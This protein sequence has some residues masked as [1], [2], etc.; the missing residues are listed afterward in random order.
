MLPDTAL[1]S[2][3]SLL[4]A[5]RDAT[6]VDTDWSADASLHFLRNYTTE[7]VDPY[8]QFH[9]VRDDIR[10]AISHGGYDTMVQELLDP[11]SDVRRDQ[12]DV[13]VMSLLVDF[14]DARCVEPEWSADDCIAKIDELVGH[15]VEKTSSLLVLNTLLP[16]VDHL[17]DGAT[18]ASL[19][20]EISRVNKR[21]LELQSR[22]SSRLIVS[23]FHELYRRSGEVDAL[24][25]RFWRA[26]QAPFRKSFLDL[27]ARDIA[28]HIRV[29]KGRSRKCL[30]LDCD[31]TLWGGVIGEEG[32][33]GI[34]LHDSDKPG[35]YFRAFQ[36]A[37]VALHDQG[38]MLAVCSKNNEDDVWEVL[39]NHPYCALKKSHLVA[40]RIN[41]EN[42][43]ANLVSLADELN[44]GLDSFVFVDDSPHERALVG[45]AL[46]DVLVLGVPDELE[47]LSNMLDSDRL[48][49]TSSGSDEDRQR[50]QM[51]R[52]ESERKREQNGYDDLT[53]YLSTL[54]TVLRIFPVDSANKARVAQL[55]Q[56]TNQFNLTT[57]RYSEADI[58]GFLENEDVA[59][60]AMSVEDR[61]GSMGITGV[62]IGR[63]DGS[64]ALIDS[65]LL[66]CRVLGRQLEFAFVDQCLRLL[67]KRW[68]KLT[69]HADFFPTRKNAQ[70]ADFWDRAGFVLE[71]DLDGS[72]HYLLPD[73]SGSA[74]YLNI[75]SVKLE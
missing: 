64:S 46:P 61:Y 3:G 14:L 16:P 31:N 36:E 39:D 71:S 72:R 42:K 70:V 15:V 2:L 22:H 27:Y 35:V 63:R 19:E 58:E 43:A 4:D 24:D 47:N 60:F 51:Y 49:D 32:L 53:D 40:W 6:A 18:E 41:W 38:V 37:A 21:I 50:T 10:P 20:T 55:T 59:I 33:D 73:V 34:Q 13:I 52:Q 7:S 17:L 69:W 8:L 29:L 25:K 12:P 57:R 11:G 9:L 45:A 68:G 56:K 75:I 30:V 48:F 28:Y 44:I 67:A 74:D 54:E 65:L 23:D 62:L 26:S 66:S 1:G 5:I